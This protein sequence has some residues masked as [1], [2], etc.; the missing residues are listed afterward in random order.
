MI[1]SNCKKN[2]SCSSNASC[3]CMNFPKIKS[4]SYEQVDCYCSQCLLQMISNKVNKDPTSLSDIEKSEIANFGIPSVP[5]E[6]QDFY[7]NDN[8]LYTFTSW[9][10]L[11]RGYCCENGCRHCPY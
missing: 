7:I 3:W 11:R 6:G 1:C 10:L 8:G 4:K 2:N 5:I 9:Y